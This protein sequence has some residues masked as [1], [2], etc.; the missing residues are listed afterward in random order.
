[1][2]AVE[3]VRSLFASP[4]AEPVFVFGNQKSGTT[5]IAALL[6]RATGLAA[7]LDFHGA[8]EPHLGRLLRGELSIDRFV[9]S[10]SYPLSKAII[11]EP[12]LT[13]VADKLMDH[14]ACN[15]A[16]FVVR[17]P[18]ANIR[19]SLARLSIPGD[20]DWLSLGDAWLPNPTWHAIL[21][22][23]DL[24]S[25]Y[26]HYVDVLAHRWNAAAAVYFRNPHR[27][28]LIRYEDFLQDK[29]Q[30]VHSIACA[31]NLPVVR[32][33]APYVNVQ[34][35]V[36]SDKSVSIDAFFGGRNL[37]RINTICSRYMNMLRYD[38]E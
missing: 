7:T 17:D 4:V 24:D 15:K 36:V 27:Y 18:R 14:F 8:R 22:G 5:A 30:S 2:S 20:L 25:D 12:N 9:A 29:V 33:I 31:L 37:S 23:R 38:A 32:D 1:M 19:S 34:Y 6:S 3:S 13:F 35:Q 16:V 26:T 10:N 21:E 28:V 11:K